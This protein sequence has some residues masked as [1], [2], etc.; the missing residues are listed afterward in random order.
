MMDVLKQR[1]LAVL[2]PF[3]QGHLLR[4]WDALSSAKRD[5][6]AKEIE[7]I[8]FRLLSELFGQT[9][10]KAAIRRLAARASSPAF[11][12]LG[13]AANSI[14]PDK[15]RQ[16]GIDALRS[17]RV[18]AMLVAGGQ[19]T[20]LGFPHP[21][22]M[23]PIG[24][25]SGKTLFQIHLEKVLAASLRYGVRIPLY[26]MT[27]P[28]THDETEA[29]LARHGRF[30]MPA[31]DL[32]LFCQ[33]TMPA[34][35]AKTGKAILADRHHLA[36]SPDGHGGMVAAF[37][38]G[39]A[40]DDALRRGIRHLFYFQVDNPLVHV[41]DPEFLGYHLL[42]GSE[43]TTQVV[44]KRDPMEKVG[45]VIQVDGRL[46]VIEYS[47]LPDDVA[48]RRAGDGSLEIWAG[49]IA[50]HAI[51]LRFLERVASAAAGL[52]FHRAHKKVPYLD[53]QGNLVRPS[54]PNA[55]KFERFI[56]DLMPMAERAI[57]VEVDPAWHFAPLKNASGHS[58]DTPE[59]VQAQLSA[60]YRNWLRGAGF[61]VAD[62][63][64]VEIS[65]RFALDAEEFQ[66]R[67]LARKPIVEPTYFG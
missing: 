11:F 26:V 4:F 32:V 61:E 57:V 40:M 59:S 38:R 65:P 62:G 49:S 25:V 48:T 8:D 47:D 54:Q 67:M 10:D 53:E 43:F 58:T 46:H 5:A 66:S 33:G 27:S 2:E 31:S 9:D 36:L 21:K 51:E 64:P 56:F 34:V 30:G 37:H 14:P 35:D 1:L 6:L 42:S 13:D 63:V 18:A 7:A 28:E 23:F 39:G 29:F 55:I 50:V 45:N 16:R 19:G 3:G 24:P 20:R 15:A 52:P 60:L 44:R 12:R 17:G 41:C 22:G